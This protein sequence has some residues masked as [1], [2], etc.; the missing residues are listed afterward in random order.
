MDAGAAASAH[1]LKRP[2]EETPGGAAKLAKLAAP[3]REDFSVS[4]NEAL[5]FRLAWSAEGL[6]DAPQFNPAF[7]HQVFREDE[8]I[9][10]FREL[11]ARALRCSAL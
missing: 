10:G 3:S 4:A 2:S 7:T 8:T 1:A 11:E 5:S 9:W 6:D